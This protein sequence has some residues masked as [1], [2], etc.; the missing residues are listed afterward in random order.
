M[1]FRMEKSSYLMIIVMLLTVA[2]FMLSGASF[3]LNAI[4]YLQVLG[5]SVLSVIA[6]IAIASIPV[7]IYCYFKKVIPDIDYSINLAFAVTII[8]LISEII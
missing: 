1:D 2:Y 6:L 8:G 7:V 5:F 3:E 4:G